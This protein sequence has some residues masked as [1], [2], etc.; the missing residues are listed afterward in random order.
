[1]PASK[2]SRQSAR[3]MSQPR[4]VDRAGLKPHSEPVGGG[5]QLGEAP[6]CDIT[7]KHGRGRISDAGPF[8][9]CA[10]TSG[11]LAQRSGFLYAIAVCTRSSRAPDSQGLS[12]GTLS[13]RW[14]A[15]AYPRGPKKI[16]KLSSSCER[17]TTVFHRKGEL[18]PVVFHLIPANACC[19]RTTGRSSVPVREKR[20]GRREK[21]VVRAVLAQQLREVHIIQGL[22]WRSPAK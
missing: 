10:H 5:E 14:R 8:W 15:H 21:N 3:I 16:N 4:Q 19:A 13:P 2:Q 6:F 18:Q 17:L 20:R 11:N 22:C 9:H 7:A 12:C 1:M